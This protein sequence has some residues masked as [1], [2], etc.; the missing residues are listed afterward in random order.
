MIKKGLVILLG[1]FLVFGGMT[2][3]TNKKEVTEI[4]EEQ[5][6]VEDNETNNAVSE[7]EEPTNEKP[8]SENEMQTIVLY[9]L[10]E[11]GEL[12]KNEIQVAQFDENTIWTYLQENGT[13]EPG[14]QIISFSQD[15]TNKRLT[16]DL[17]HTFGDRLRSVGT[18]EEKEILS[19]IVNSYLD[20]YECEQIKITESGAIL[21]SGHTAYEDYMGK[22]TLN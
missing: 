14:E 6:E 10:D 19:C 4:K 15:K 5:K 18:R 12:A 9:S 2:G 13:V 7:P 8:E 11:M 20:T 3:C 17:N 22:I 16:L 1:A 21:E